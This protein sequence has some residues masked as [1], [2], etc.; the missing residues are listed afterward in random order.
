MSYIL[1]ALKKSEQERQLGAVP[2]PEAG[3]A[4]GRR[5]ARPWWPW[6]LSGVLLVNAAIL[7]WLVLRPQT[8]VPL[9]QQETTGSRA[10][11][12][13]SAA[14]AQP[15]EAAEPAAA[16]SRMPLPTAA[17]AVSALPPQS[18]P[19][20]VESVAPAP[21]A[22]AQP[23]R[24]SVRWMAPPEPEAPAQPAEAVP[25]QAP[26]WDEL[27]AAEKNGLIRP[28]LDVHV[29][30]ESPAQRFVLIDLKRYR[31]GEQLAGGGRLEAITPEGVII[32]ARGTRYRVDRP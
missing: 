15:D 19:P 13:A 4:M 3:I 27:S 25:P 11:A 5:P 24:G 9:S 17:A 28:R 22:P 23:S 2:R 8:P 7:L 26:R 29:Y 30:A 14:A 12:S 32:E 21:V 18:P 10:A 16:R 31:E 20:A 6:L 1:E